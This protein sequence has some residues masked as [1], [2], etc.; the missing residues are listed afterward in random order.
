[1][2]VRTWKTIFR[3]LNFCFFSV[4]P[5]LHP[6]PFPISC[7]LRSGTLPSSQRPELRH[8][9]SLAWGPG[10]TCAPGQ[11]RRSDHVQDSTAGSSCLSAPRGTWGAVYPKTRFLQAT[12]WSC[13]KMTSSALQQLWSF[14]C[15]RDSPTALWRLVN[16]RLLGLPPE[17][18]IEQ[19][20][21]RNSSQ[22]AHF[23]NS[24]FLSA[25]ISMRDFH[26]HSDTRMLLLTVLWQHVSQLCKIK[27]SPNDRN[28]VKLKVELIQ[29]VY[30]TIVYP[31]YHFNM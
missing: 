3:I 1:M 2:S 29:V 10:C 22:K 28:K 4:L 23:R 27:I 20:W 26:Q 14:S 8:G 24:F 13:L 17:L 25:S 31:K 11:R 18:L 7:A 5:P 6:S 30:F 12:A 21:G 9:V 15:V 19:A 16:H